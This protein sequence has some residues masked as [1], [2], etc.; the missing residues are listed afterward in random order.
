MNSLQT[1]SIPYLP[2]SW[3]R[4]DTANPLFNVVNLPYSSPGW[5]PTAEISHGYSFDQVFGEYLRLRPDGFVLQSCSRPLRD[6]LIRQGCQAAAM[7]AEAVLDL[8]WRGKRSVRDLARQGRRHGTVHEIECS[9][10]DQKK[11]AQLSR[12]TPPRQG[13]QLRHTGRPRFDDSTRCFILETT[14]YKWLGAITLSTPA[15]NYVHTELLIRHREV[16][17]G[18]MEAIITSIADQLALEGVQHLSLGAVTPLPAAESKTIFAAHRHP[19]ELWTRSQFF[20]RLGRALKFAYDAEGLWRF[21]NKFSPRWEPLYLCA[22]P[23]LS[24]ATIAGLIQ[25]TG[26]LSL[27]Q[28]QLLGSW[29][30]SLPTL[31][32]LF[33]PIDAFQL[34]R[35]RGFANGKS[36]CSYQPGSARYSGM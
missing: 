13:V 22:S 35:M 6:Y 4:T 5:I 24:W 1:D 36:P 31:R 8:P 9:R 29:S 21:K 27:V 16:P 25:A 28:S 18:I 34:F 33:P 15:P 32:S 19:K 10:N 12:D 30:I 26:Y 3:T 14:E 23:S 20:F 11:L 2:L 7:G 17:V